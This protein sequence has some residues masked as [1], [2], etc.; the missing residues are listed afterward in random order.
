MLVI[1]ILAAI[2]IVLGLL[3]PYHELWKR[4]GRVVGINW[5]FLSFD[6]SGAFFSLMAL[7][8]CLTRRIRA[9]C[10]G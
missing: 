3:S 6:W 2:L 4:R 1:G 5:I 7:G 10:I 9:S 8:M